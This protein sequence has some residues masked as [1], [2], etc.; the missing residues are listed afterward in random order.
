MMEMPCQNI[1]Y[2]RKHLYQIVRSACTWSI[3][4]GRYG[5]TL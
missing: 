5:V 1:Q 2:F 4:T 3:Y